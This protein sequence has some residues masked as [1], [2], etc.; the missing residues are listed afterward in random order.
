MMFNN[1]DDV[2]LPANDVDELDDD[3]DQ[4]A[5]VDYDNDDDDTLV[6]I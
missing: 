4:D 3:E 5:D 2:G 6:V 1:D